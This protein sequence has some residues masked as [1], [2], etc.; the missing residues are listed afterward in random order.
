M[1]ELVIRALTE[2]DAYLFDTLDDPTAGLVGHLPFGHRYVTAAQGGQY[3]PEWTWVALRDGVVVARAAWWAGPEDARPVALD[4][5]D[6]APGE[7]DAAVRLLRTAP[8][9]AEYV[10]QL[11]PGWRDRPAVRDAARA[12]TDVAAAAGLVPL[13]ERF[14]YTWTPECGLPEQPGRLVFRPE[15]DDGVF[16]DILR[17][18]ETGSLDAH[19]RQAIAE[20]GVEQAAQ[21]ELAF[22]RWCPS[23]RDW[24]RVAWTA[25]PG[26]GG[27][28]VGLHVPA[29]NLRSPVIGFI[30]VVPEHRGRGYGYDLL[31]DCTRH[32]AE[33]GAE[34]IVGETD[35]PNVPM[36][37]AFAKAGYPMTQERACF[38]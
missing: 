7:S 27:E 36:A 19:A 18:V 15:P 13:V 9:H 12:R 30:G 2:S 10:L 22:F 33:H 34:R 28:P 4:W 11:P 26:R 3:R 21:E 38:V 17:R 37:A 1:T 5:L 8:L 35:Q 31:A 29:R 32:L 23:P 6:F 24:W 20:G 16:L 25:G 14:R